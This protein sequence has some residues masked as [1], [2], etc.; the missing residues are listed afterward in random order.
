MQLFSADATQQKKLK[1]KIALEKLKKTLKKVAQNQ[2]KPF[3]FKVQPRPTARSPKL[4]FHIIKSWDQ[5]SVLLSV[6]C[7]QTNE[8]TKETQ[9]SKRDFHFICYAFLC[10]LR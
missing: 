4:I 1:K 9:L 8:E 7:A 2:P 10:L 5:R 3:Y 6:P